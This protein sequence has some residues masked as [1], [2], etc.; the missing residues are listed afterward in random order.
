LQ[1]PSLGVKFAQVK[2]FLKTF[3]PIAGAG[4]LLKPRK[5]TIE[6]ESIVPAPI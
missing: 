4:K 5:H 3:Q 2:G 1:L 6:W